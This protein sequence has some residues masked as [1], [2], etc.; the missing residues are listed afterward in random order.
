MKIRSA[1]PEN[2]CLVF[3]DGRKKQKKNKKHL[4]NIRIRL[5]GGCINYTMSSDWFIIVIFRPSSFALYSSIQ[6]FAASVSSWIQSSNSGFIYLLKTCNFSHTRHIPINDNRN[7]D[8]SWTNHNASSK[9]CCVP[10]S[11][12]DVVKS[13]GSLTL[14]FS[15]TASSSRRTFW[16][17]Q[18]CIH[19]SMLSMSCSH[20]ICLPWF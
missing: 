18:S 7:I 6:H 4:Q 10:V 20:Y 2:G 16:T 15:N 1:V 8:D 17:K 19:R 9:A 14:M 12:I 11:V 13:L 5:I 3:Y